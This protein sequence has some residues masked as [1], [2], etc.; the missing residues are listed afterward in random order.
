MQET[1]EVKEAAEME[2][3]E[4]DGPGG[5]EKQEAQADEVIVGMVSLQEEAPPAITYAEMARVRE[6]A[7]ARA[8]SETR[9]GGE[10]RKDAGIDAPIGGEEENGPP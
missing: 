4:K 1:E 8:E 10:D 3:E 5:A 6:E 9:R 7:R 2:R